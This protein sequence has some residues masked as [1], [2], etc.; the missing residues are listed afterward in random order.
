[1]LARWGGD[2][3]VILLPE[4][5][6]A[7]AIRVLET[8]REQVATTL[9]TSGGLPVSVSAGVAAYQPGDTMDTLL[10]RADE[11]LYQAKRLGRNRVQGA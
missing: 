7:A 6:E 9:G 3:F 1:V 4:C 5:E 2:E 11:R 8:I 10:N